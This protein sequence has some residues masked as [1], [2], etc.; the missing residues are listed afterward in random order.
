[1]S[2]PIPHIWRGN[3]WRRHVLSWGLLFN[4]KAFRRC[5]ERHCEVNLRAMGGL[6]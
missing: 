4:G 1:M 6:R 5:S 3:G 2:E